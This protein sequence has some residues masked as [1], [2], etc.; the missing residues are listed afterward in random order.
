[1][2]NIKPLLLRN[3]MPKLSA[4]IDPS[5]IAKIDP[6]LL[7]L[8]QCNKADKLVWSTIEIAKSISR[9]GETDCPQLS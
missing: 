6:S 3:H 8:V 9:C 5:L 1:M 7:F 4:R 2:Q